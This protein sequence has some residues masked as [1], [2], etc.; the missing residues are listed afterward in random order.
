[1]K[2]MNKISVLVIV[3]VIL[4]PITYGGKEQV[5]ELK[6]KITKTNEVSLED[7]KVYFGYA[8]KGPGKKEDYKIAVYGKNNKK[9]EFYFPVYFLVG[10]PTIEVNVI[11][12]VLY[13]PYVEDIRYVEF[14]YKGKILGTFQLGDQ[15]C[16]LDD[17][18]KDKENHISCPTDCSSYSLDGLCTPVED[19][20]C[21]PDC[22][23]QKDPD[24]RS[25][26]ISNEKFPN[27]VK[28]IVIIVI[29]T[30]LVF[31]VYKI[32]KK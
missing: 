32:F 20:E 28:Y 2:L 4:I 6:L 19:D 23:I 21:D 8:E 11:Q 5:L 9:E 22:I 18:C 14:Y 17:A 25:R 7:F 12:K 1:M 30:L 29:I 15:L 27:Y 13:I 26:Q 3:L 31:V 10:H 24:C 16:N